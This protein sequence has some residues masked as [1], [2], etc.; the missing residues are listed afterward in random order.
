M[1]HVL[2]WI[3]WA[4]SRDRKLEVN[5]W[6][7]PNTN[8]SVVYDGQGIFYVRKRT[9]HTWQR[10]EG[11]VFDLL[12]MLTHIELGYLEEIQ[13]LEQ[14]TTRVKEANFTMFGLTEGSTTHEQLEQTFRELV[15]VLGSPLNDSKQRA[16]DQLVRCISFRDSLGRFNVCA[17]QART[18]AARNRLMERHW[19]IGSMKPWIALRFKAIE[20]LKDS[21][22]YLNWC[23]LTNLKNAEKLILQKAEGEK[24][25]T[26]I[27][28]IQSVK[29]DAKQLVLPPFTPSV[30]EVIVLLE[31]ALQKVRFGKLVEG[32]RLLRN[33]REYFHLKMIRQIIED[34][35]ISVVTMIAQDK[36]Q[37]VAFVRQLNR[38]QRGLRMIVEH[39]AI[40]QE[41]ADDLAEALELIPEQGHMEL[42]TLESIKQCLKAACAAL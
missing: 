40:R 15:E 35:L 26:A 39:K 37:K 5:A 21:L 20:Y 38:A 22:M 42:E 1:I 9:P 25:P 13:T 41:A 24:S 19:E 23:C 36:T 17:M 32:R 8:G 27:A 3:S 33:A 14:L 4:K 16:Q 18:V 28:H 11:G 30:E 12:R 6:E 29:S 10:V 34:Q 2:N 31:G 7:V